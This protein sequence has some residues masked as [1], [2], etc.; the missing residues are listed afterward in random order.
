[1]PADSSV[2]SMLGTSIM[3]AA[4]VS[5]VDLNLLVALDALLTERNV[6]RAAARVGL[7]QPAMSHA[8]ARLRRLFDD[9]LFV[10]TRGGILPT[11][12]AEQLQE[13]IRRA[14]REIE[15]AL[16]GGPT[17]DPKTAQAT[18]TI[19]TSD[20][21]AF[22]LVPDLAAAIAR[23]APGIDLRVL[24]IPEPLGSELEDGSIDLVIGLTTGVPES[25]RRQKLFDERFVCV[26]REGH[27]A[28]EKPLTLTRFLALRHALVAPRGRAGGIVDDLLAA[29]GLSRRVAL[30]VPHFLVAPRVIART[31][32]VLTLAGRVADA[33]AEHEG[34]VVVPPPLALSGFSF[35]AL[36]HVRRTRD[37]G[38]AW[39][40]AKVLDAAGGTRGRRRG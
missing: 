31:D 39:L 36:W 8:L 18:F 28:A 27:P 38:H 23:E 1:M 19:A 6:T 37:P 40:R 4:H 33:F 30:T 25:L 5:S 10:R 20:Y 17:F 26:M 15:G 35:H 2:Q 11:S 34:L 16:H 32:L 3:H 22:V 14:L 21:G 7:T 24:A 9:P 29:R 13:P 12:R